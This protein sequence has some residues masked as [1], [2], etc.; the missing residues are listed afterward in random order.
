MEIRRQ[1]QP[2]LKDYYAFNRHHFRRH[3]I[4]RPIVYIVLFIVGGIIGISQNPVSFTPV[5]IY[6]SVASIVIILMALYFQFYIKAHARKQYDSSPI[7]K[8][9]TEI[10]IAPVGIRESS[11]KYTLTLDWNDLYK[12][13]SSEDGI[14]IYFSRYQAVILP[15]RLLSDDDYAAVFEL[16]K[17]HMPPAKNR[18][19]PEFQDPDDI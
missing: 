5:I 13:E 2:T 9:E 14:Y 3:A 16:V 6:F 4:V 17:Q 18:M 7:T 11:N 1:Y 12:A 15:M 8:A 10:V 19:K